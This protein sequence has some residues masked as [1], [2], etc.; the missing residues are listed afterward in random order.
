MASA[1]IS[2]VIWR[3]GQA[4][5]RAEGTNYTDGELLDRYRTDRDEAAFAALIRRHGPM[6]YGVCRRT[7]RNEADAEDA[8]QATFLV[9][10][11]KAH[12]INPPG[13]VGHWLYG[14][15]CN[16]ARKARTMNRRRI[17]REHRAGIERLAY[18]RSFDRLEWHEALDIELG[19]LPE[20]YREAVVTCDLEGEPLKDAARRLDCP[21]GTIASRLARG[22]SML[23]EKL[24][25]RGLAL[26]AFLAPG[27]ACGSIPAKLAQF[28]THAAIGAA[29]VPTTVLK[30]T[31]G[32]I[33]AMFIAKLKTALAAVF[34]A[35]MLVAGIGN[36]SAI[37]WADGEKPTKPAKPPDPVKPIKPGE[38]PAKPDKPA[39][40]VKKSPA[41][42][43]TLKVIDTAK[44]SITITVT[45]GDA[46]ID[47]DF[48][49]ARDIRVVVDGKEA[50][51][52]DLKVGAKVSVKLGDDKTTV[53][54]IATGAGDA[55]NKKAQGGAGKLKSVDV[56]KGNIT[57]TAIKGDT[58]I[59]RTYPIGASVKVFINGEPATLKDLKVSA[60]VTVKL[61]DDRTTVVGIG[62]EGPTI[63]GDLK[64][65]AADNKS[66]TVTV[67][68][69]TDKT[70]KSSVKVEDKSIKVA[71]DLRI[72]IEG[73]KSA[74]LADLS[75]GT[76]VAVRM[77]NDGEHAI[78]ITSPAKRADGDVKKPMKP[79]GDKP[80]PE[81]PEKPNTDK[82]KPEKPVRP[83]VKKP[84]K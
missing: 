21:P 38:K 61:G 80:K 18:D 78:T 63:V 4:A 43:G 12:A 9:L 76:S 72:K 67:K 29:P 52:A 65:V 16:T 62:S 47:R 26:S 23:R 68:T 71:D 40:D 24:A 57:I 49:L 75:A 44:Q 11:R 28:T 82:P 51:L 17:D 46:S 8:F 53:V 37:V 20:K 19:R 70:D 77:S 55:D 39:G 54:A 25:R 50:K 7:L 22:R 64:S 73:Q 42:S 3:I 74:T 36:S 2:N 1:G 6:V 10:A 45:K 48:S 30:L 35:G 14:V 59:D 34:V 31:E 60:P 13:R 66:I 84:A 83:E 27:I 15:A 79:E 33:H 41:F 58:S 81:K 56:A 69:L 32:V 5:L